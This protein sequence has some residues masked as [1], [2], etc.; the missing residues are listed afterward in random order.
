VGAAPLADNDTPSGGGLEG[1]F[2]KKLGPVP[3]WGWALGAAAIGGYLWYRRS[4][5][6][7]SSAA[8]TTSA[9]STAQN[10]DYGPSIAAQQSEIQAL[11]YGQSQDAAEDQG[12]PGAKPPVP[13][14]GPPTKTFQVTR[15]LAGWVHGLSP[16]DRAKLGTAK[17]SSIPGEK[18]FD[19]QL[20][21]LTPAEL[22]YLGATDIARV[23]VGAH[24]R[25]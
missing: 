10:F 22:H 5:A 18:A 12:Q 19:S 20:K 24:T 21:I 16:Q 11:Q 23:P 4:Q 3:V 15:Q 1:F 7:N 8:S 14:T 6:A 2:S 25:K 13:A 17:Q 9:A